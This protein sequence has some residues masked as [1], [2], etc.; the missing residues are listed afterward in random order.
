MTPDKQD[1]DNLTTYPNPFNPAKDPVLYFGFTV[2]QK[3][4]D[5]IGVKIYTNA[6]RKIRDE[7]VSGPDKDA[8]INNARIGLQAYKTGNIAGG[9]YFY[10]I[11]AEKQGIITRSKPGVLLI[12]R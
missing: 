9:V 7:K 5:S 3:D 8:A 11:Y 6:F 10:Y 12:V 1:I 4:C 2:K